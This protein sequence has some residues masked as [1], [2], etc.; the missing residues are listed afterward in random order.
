MGILK[1]LAILVGI[2]SG[3]ILALAVVG[4]MV[5]GLGDYGLQSFL[6]LVAVGGIGMI[7]AW[8]L[9]RAG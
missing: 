9:D 7:V 8:W 4:L 2:V 5:K 3:L 6:L 1:V